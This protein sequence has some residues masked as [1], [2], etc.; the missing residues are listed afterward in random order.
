MDLW[1]VIGAAGLNVLKV[2]R[3]GDGNKG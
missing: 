3:A 2:L 1:A